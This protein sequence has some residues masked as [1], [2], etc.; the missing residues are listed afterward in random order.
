[1]QETAKVNYVQYGMGSKSKNE[2]KSG[3]KFQGTSNGGSSG[4]TGNP[5]RSGGKDRKVPLLTRHLLEMWQRQ[6][7][8]WTA[9]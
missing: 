2:S 5:S 9:L 7:S 3:G 6:T 8:K 4:S 1:M